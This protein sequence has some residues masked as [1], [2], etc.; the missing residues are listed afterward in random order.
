MIAKDQ[1]LLINI[2]PKQL[3]SKW[4]KVAWDIGYQLYFNY[5]SSILFRNDLSTNINGKHN[6]NLT[7]LFTPP[8]PT[9]V[10]HDYMD[11]VMY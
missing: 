1:T 11:D 6:P 9:D 5:A 8:G 7:S 3:T 4:L 10:V 2:K